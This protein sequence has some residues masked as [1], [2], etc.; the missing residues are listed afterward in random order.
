MTDEPDPAKRKRI[1]EE[2]G[3]PFGTPIAPEQ[4]QSPTSKEVAREE[5]TRPEGIEGYR[6]ELGR[7]EKQG[8]PTRKKEP[9]AAPPTMRR[10]S[11]EKRHERE[12]VEEQGD[13]LGTPMAPEQPQLGTDE[14]TGR[15]EPTSAEG[16]DKYRSEHQTEDIEEG[17]K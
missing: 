12:Y 1:E 6:S 7:P 3:S 16:L 13:T 17:K 5:P 2:Q 4:P 11:K 15:Q 8:K 10:E 14:T 9:E